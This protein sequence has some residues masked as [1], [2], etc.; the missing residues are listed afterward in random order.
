MSM[1]DLV[2]TGAQ[3]FGAQSLDEL[4]REA[5]SLG[6][7]SVDHTFEQYVEITFTNRAGS[8]IY[9]RGKHT[10]IY[11]AFRMAIVEAKNLGATP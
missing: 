1:L 11:Q 3:T 6:K 8:R 7:V 2:R 5:S 4:W 9:A 10:D